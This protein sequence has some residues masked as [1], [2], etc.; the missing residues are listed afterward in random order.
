M[1]DAFVCNRSWQFPALTID[2]RTALKNIRTARDIDV[3]V[4][5]GDELGSVGKRPSET[6]VEVLLSADGRDRVERRSTDG[7]RRPH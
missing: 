6:I 3:V 7:R 5:S 1:R 4:E 2:T